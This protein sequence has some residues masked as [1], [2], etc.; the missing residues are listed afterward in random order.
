MFNVLRFHDSTEAIDIAQ[1]GLKLNELVPGL[2]DGLDRKSS[3]RF[4][5]SVCSD[6]GWPLQRQ[7]MIDTLHKS[8]AV[9][10]DALAKGVGIQFDLAI[11]PEDYGKAWLTEVWLDLELLYHLQAHQVEFV[12]SIY[13]SG[14]IT[15]ERG[16][17][18]S[19][20]S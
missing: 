17:K 7:A 19:A 5:C 20:N 15:G 1:F 13:G 2:Y 9:I 3:H 14:E 8:S 12:M 6:D 16:N 10:R 11:D 4:S 18:G